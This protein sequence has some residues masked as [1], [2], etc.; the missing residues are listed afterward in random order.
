MPAARL[1][2]PREHH[3]RIP[4]VLPPPSGFTAFVVAHRNSPSRSVPPQ[5][6]HCGRWKYGQFGVAVQFVLL[7]VTWGSSFL[8]IKLGLAGLSPMQVVWARLVFGALALGSV[9]LFTRK[10]VP[11]EPVVWAHLTVVAMLLCVVPFTLFAWAE[12]HISSGMAS[13][14]NATTPLTTVAFTAVALRSERL[15][16]ARAAGLALGFAGVLLLI[17]PMAVGTSHD[18]LGNLACLGATVCYGAAFCYLRA[19]VAHRDLPAVSVAFV[20]VA[21]GAAVMVLATPVVA[22]GAMNLTPTVVVSMV[23]LGAVGTGLAYIWNTNVVRSW[24]ATRGASVTYATPVVGVALGVVLLDE[25]LTWN[26]P[27]GAA[28]VVAGIVVA[29]GRIPRAVSAVGRRAG[30]PPPQDAPGARPRRRGGRPE[31]RR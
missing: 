25:S 10:P 7:A 23:V 17:A 9:V 5:V 4:P 19:F 15:T 11:R 21:S 3:V 24:G 2:A 1:K 30:T 20:Q 26:Q 6:A 28:L 18:L 31:L 29:G 22:G 12:L 16:K 14:W 13:I 27:V 8:L